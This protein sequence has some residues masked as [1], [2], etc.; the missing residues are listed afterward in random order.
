MIIDKR[1]FTI[2]TVD[3]WNCSDCNPKIAV[4]WFKLNMNRSHKWS[5]NDSFTFTIKFFN[6]GLYILINWNFDSEREA[7]SKRH[8]KELF[9]DNL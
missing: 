1:H 6:W 5:Y 3:E 8:I 2:M 7:S 9:G 4:D